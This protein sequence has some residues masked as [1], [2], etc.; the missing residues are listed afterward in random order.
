[1]GENKIIDNEKLLKDRDQNYNYQIKNYEKDYKKTI[2]VIENMKIENN[3]LIN[4][5]NGEI[6]LLKEEYNKNV[7]D[8]KNEYNLLKE[9]MKNMK[10]KILKHERNN[11]ILDNKV[12]F[13]DKKILHL[14]HDILITGRKLEQSNNIYKKLIKDL[15]KEKETNLMH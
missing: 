10:T 1:M 12:R 11:I 2:T 5:Y 3:K 6:N 13:K 14:E 9:N 15:A 8:F 4:K 7:L